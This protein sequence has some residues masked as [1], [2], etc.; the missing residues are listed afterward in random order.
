M[1]SSDKQIVDVYRGT[2]TLHRSHPFDFVAVNIAVPFSGHLVQLS[3][4]QAESKE[5]LS[6]PLPNHTKTFYPSIPCGT[7]VAF[8]ERLMQRLQVDRK[9]LS[10]TH[11]AFDL[12]YINSSYLH[13]LLEIFI[14]IV[15][16]C[17]N[18][19]FF[20]EKALLENFG[21]DGTLNIFWVFLFC[22]SFLRKGRLFEQCWQKIIG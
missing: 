20:K 11:R 8:G 2:S 5:K 7:R 13:L 4:G 12:K 21:E 17:R 18:Q 19:N 14:V 10:I 9:F 6:R 22:F 1:R 15:Y 3:T 16:W